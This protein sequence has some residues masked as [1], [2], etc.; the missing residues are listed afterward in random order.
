MHAAYGDE[1]A[2]RK[3]NV[4]FGHSGIHTR[5]SVLPDFDKSRN[6]HV[7]FNGTPSKANVG[8]RI[9]HFR[10]QAVPLAV[11][12]IDDAYSSAGISRSDSPITHLITVTCTGLSAP[13]IDADILRA[14]GLPEDIYRLSVNFLGCNAAFHAL[15]VA[16]L[17]CS[18]DPS[19]NVMIVC[20][21]LCTLHFQPKNNH[22]NLLSNTVFGDGAAALLI[23]GD[24]KAAA[25]GQA[26]LTIQGSYGLLLDAGKDLMGWNVTPVT[27]EMI[28]SAKIPDFIGAHVESI[29]HKAGKNLGITPSQIQH[30]AI[31]PGGKKILDT[32]QR[33]LALTDMEMIPS[34]SVLRDFGNMS[35]PTVLFVLKE[36]L[37]SQPREGDHIF[38]IGF[39][40]GLSIETALFKYAR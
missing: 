3:L 40:P 36:I 27:F 33:H 4:L 12:A 25:L 11:A 39:G 1:T 34:Y 10:E 6:E 35:S 17:I 23:T 38:S 24:Q 37:E 22:D 29:L 26:G 18:K 16:D 5:Y 19:A 2:S 7:F 20:V 14:L 31:H 21:E 28:L 32:I 30:W 13:G 15:K 9:G 8:D